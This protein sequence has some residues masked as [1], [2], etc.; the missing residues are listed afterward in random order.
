MCQLGG[1]LLLISCGAIFTYLITRQQTVEQTLTLFTLVL[2]I[3]LCLLSSLA[4]FNFWVE[5]LVI[6]ILFK[7]EGVWLV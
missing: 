1:S 3:G 6:T 4:T 2:I 7:L 5:V